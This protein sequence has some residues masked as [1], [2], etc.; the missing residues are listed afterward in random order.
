MCTVHITGVYMPVFGS[1]TYCTTRSLICPKNYEGM[2]IFGLRSTYVQ[3]MTYTGIRILSN[4]YLRYAELPIFG[5][6]TRTYL[7]YAG[8]RMPEPLPSS[9]S[10]PDIFSCRKEK[11]SSNPFNHLFILRY[12]KGSFP[13][14]EAVFL[15]MVFN[16]RG[17]SIGKD[18]VFLLLSDWL[19]LP[20]NNHSTVLTS[21]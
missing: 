3:Y 2:H 17:N 13:G 16:L 4:I 8:T 18:L 10:L 6:L 20:L 9:H 5:L 7:R 14:C 11:C 15:S 12:H 1:R 21:R 19:P